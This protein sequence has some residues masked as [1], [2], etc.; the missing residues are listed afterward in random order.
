MGND[1]TIERLRPPFAG[2]Q[3]S[4]KDFGNRSDALAII[5]CKMRV[6][7]VGYRCVCFELV[8]NLQEFRSL[9]R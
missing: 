8:Q 2:S 3:W 7:T 1:G 9:K 6:R 5:T 4:I